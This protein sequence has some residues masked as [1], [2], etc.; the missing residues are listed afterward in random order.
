MQ[1]DYGQKSAPFRGCIED[2][3]IPCSCST[4]GCNI[5]FS[6]GFVVFAVVLFLGLVL[7]CFD[8]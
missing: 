5:S 2:V 6:D 4:K 3:L 1:S 8:F 7:C